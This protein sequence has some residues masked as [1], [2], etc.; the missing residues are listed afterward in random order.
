MYAYERMTINGKLPRNV[1]VIFFSSVKPS[2]AYA[3]YY[4]CM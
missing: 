1:V 2:R 3:M 4:N